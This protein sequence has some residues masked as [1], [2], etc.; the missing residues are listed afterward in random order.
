MPS[1]IPGR[2]LTRR[3]YVEAVGPIL[4][5]HFPT[6][7]YAAAL[8]GPGSDV[9]GFDTA[10]STD[11][12][13]GPRMALMLR[14]V[15]IQYA[16]AI[17]E[18]LCR[19]LPSTFYGYPVST[20]AGLPA[21]EGAQQSLAGVRDHRVSITTLRAFVRQ[22]L[23]YD[24]DTPLAAAD[25]LTFPSQKLR[26]LT[27]GSVHHDDVGELTALRE[28]FAFY[29]RDVWVYLLAAGWHRI[30]QEEHLMP[31][32]G[33]V[34][35][36]LGSAIIGARLI[37]DC[38]SLCFLMEKQY[39]PYPKWFGTAFQRL[40]CADTLTPLLW[41][42]QHAQ[43]WQEREAALGDVYASLAQTHNALGL[44]DPLPEAV[45]RFHGRP[46]MIIQGDIF[47]G[48]LCQCIT[49]PEV[50]SIAAR[51]LIGSIDQ[52]SD[53]TDIRSDAVWRATL[54]NLYM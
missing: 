30:A 12:D 53:S 22:H 10:M 24:V 23:A 1:F 46:F 7:P 13:W 14:A 5:A 29:P 47:A 19:Y 39:A 50:R 34:G 37:R 6:L 42:A 3:F 26:E 17:D 25:W 36:E 9:L 31:R 2:E 52:W 18:A 15:D 35:D 38:M 33:Y 40:T 8:I 28:R 44:T 11:H 27:A 48:A 49:D 16:D 45:S 41:R 32:A 4:A 51:R 54:R 20:E 21:P 43:H